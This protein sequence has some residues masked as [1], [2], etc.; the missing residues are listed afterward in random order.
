MPPDVTAES[1]MDAFVHALEAFVGARANP[2]SD[3]L[4]RRAIELI[5]S[6]IREACVRGDQN[7]NVRYAMCLGSY[8]AILAVRQTGL[9]LIHSTCYPP[10]A[11]YHLRHGYAL[12]LMMPAVMKY[13]LDSNTEKFAAVASA[14]GE[15][16]EGL[17]IRDAAL[18]AEKNVRMLITDIGLHARLRDTG[19]VKKDFAQFAEVIMKRYTH[20]F[21]N[22]PGDVNKEK[23]IG[24][25]ETAW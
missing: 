19:G 6:N 4:A 22:N 5:S 9:G 12:C 7:I 2:F 8:L 23:L 18:A 13:N 25:Y 10:A 16:I 11:K 15:N 21:S 3:I 17:S 24:I 1:G 14:M 20:H